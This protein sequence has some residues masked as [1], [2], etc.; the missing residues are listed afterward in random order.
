MKQEVPFSSKRFML[1]LTLCA[2]AVILLQNHAVSTDLSFPLQV[3]SLAL[4][5]TGCFLLF[6]PAMLLKK[7][8]GSDV[9]TLALRGG[10]VQG[11]IVAA[12]YTV[13]FLYIAVYFF[14]PYTDMFCKKY[15]TET[16]P[17]FVA[18]LLLLCCVYAVLK[19]VNVITRFG[20]F[21][22][23]L[24]L[25]TNAL[26]FGGCVSSVDFQNGSF[27][28]HGDPASFW[29]NVQYFLSP[30][31]IA[32]LFAAL[33]G[34]ARGFCVRHTVFSLLV[35]GVKY[36]LVLFFL[37]FSVGEYAKRQAYPT[38]VLSRAAHFGSFAG[39]ESLYMALSTLSVFL[40]ISLLLCGVTK[41][42]DKSGKPGWIIPFA[43]M[44]FSAL[45]AAEL[46]PPVKN[47]LTAT[48][49][50]NGC[51]VLTGAVLPGVCLLRER[52]RHG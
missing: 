18:L 10:T 1:A 52:R 34:G 46:F 9:P 43:V 20:L 8:C 42:W 41:S 47:L 5:L 23:A 51:A 25:L 40:I 38:F 39:I 37:T 7:R 3:G 36:A 4:G 32:A 49:V 35:T 2:C 50:C 13:C 14:I 33:S 28:W 48:P 45:T 19:G 11:R 24:A 12:L 27:E 30:C 15:Y 26:Q 21:L 29:G 6:I 16:S 44:I 31:F 17:V 22:F